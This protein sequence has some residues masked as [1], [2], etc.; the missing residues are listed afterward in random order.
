ML[1]TLVSGGLAFTQWQR[2]GRQMPGE[3]GDPDTR[4]RAMA[5]A[6]MASSGFSA[7]VILAQMMVE[8]LMGACQ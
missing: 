5:T 3:G 1:L 2:L 4:A 7:L 8:S 6:G